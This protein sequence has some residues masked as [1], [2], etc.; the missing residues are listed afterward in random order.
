V[1][2]QRELIVISTA[3]RVYVTKTDSVDNIDQL[4]QTLSLHT[5]VTGELE[6]VNRVRTTNSGT[7][8]GTLQTIK[9]YIMNNKAEGEVVAH[10]TNSR[11]STAWSTILL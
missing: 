9:S 11:S 10:K 5:K 8:L 4:M 2:R 3:R 1:V 6:Q 7:I